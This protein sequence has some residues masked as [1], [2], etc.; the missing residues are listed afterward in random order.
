VPDLT[1]LV[2][3]HP[4]RERMRGL[5][6]VPQPYRC[7]TRRARLCRQGRNRG[8]QRPHARALRCMAGVRR[9]CGGA[10]RAGVLP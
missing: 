1:A 5:L 4:L 9:L 7:S 6:R 2:V 3:D 8:A 10:D